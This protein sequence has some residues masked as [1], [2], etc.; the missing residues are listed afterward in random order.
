[1]TQ[2]LCGIFFGGGMC[3]CQGACI[4]LNKA[5]VVYGSDL[6]PA[7]ILFFEEGRGCV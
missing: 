6:F 1:M 3:E 4:I 7:V 5:S 2:I